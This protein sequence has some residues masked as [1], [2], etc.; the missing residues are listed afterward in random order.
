MISLSLERAWLVIPVILIVQAVRP[1]IERR[2]IDT[3]VLPW[4]AILVACILV[5]PSLVWDGAEV[6]WRLIAGAFSEGTPIGILAIV[7]YDL[8]GKPLKKIFR[9]LYYGKL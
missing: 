7:L 1:A 2:K 9:S 4:V 3:G 8:G 6:N 5:I